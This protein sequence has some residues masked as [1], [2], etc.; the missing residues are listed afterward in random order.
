MTEEK[1]AMTV[2]SA[3]LHL[4]KSTAGVWLKMSFPKIRWMQYAKALR[5]QS[6]HTE[7]TPVLKG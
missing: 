3:L 2:E 4:S 7:L 6:R 1:A 5:K